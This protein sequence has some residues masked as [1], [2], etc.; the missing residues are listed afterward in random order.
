M[1]ITSKKI[2]VTSFILIC[3][4]SA[5]GYIISKNGEGNKLSGF[6][7]IT[8]P[9]NVIF[10]IGDGMGFNTKIAADYFQNGS[11]NSQQY[12]N[13]PVKYA[14]SSF[15]AK[16]GSYPDA[17]VWSTGY[18]PREM[19]NNFSY[20]L[21]DYTESAA[22]A[23]ALSTGVKTYNNSIGMDLNFQ[24]LVNLTQV[25][26]SL[27]KSAG[28]VT[29]V[30]FSHATPAGFVAHNVT[31]NNYSV[32]AF[33]MLLNSKVDVIMGAGNPDYDNDG[34]L[35]HNSYEFV[36][37]SLC[38]IGLQAGNSVFYVNGN[39]DTVEDC[40]NDGIRDPWTLIQDKIQ[41]QTLMNGNTPL[42]VLGVPKIFQT[43]QQSRSGDASA[44]PFVVPFNQTVPALSEMTKG[45]LN[46][47]DNNSNGFFLMVECGAIDWAA[48]G[49]QK[50][51]LIE[52]TI[53]LNNTVNAVI[54]WVNTH[55]NWN[56]TLVIIT[57][58]HETGMLWGPGSGRSAVFNPIV[59]N[60]INQ[61]PGMSFYS[62]GHTNSLVPFYAN[63]QGS[64]L[65]NIFADET[66]SVRGRF[67]QNSEIAQTI[68]CLWDAAYV[69]SGVNLTGT[70]TAK[71]F[72]LDQNYPNPFNPSTTISFNLKKKAS[73]SLKIFDITG[74]LVKNLINNELTE[75]G[76]KSIKYNASGL[77][78]GVY[79]YTLDADGKRIDAKKMV[80]IK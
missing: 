4:L 64:Q 12:D 33:E 25:A 8:P 58:D 28:V 74:R 66:D 36:G 42:R 35:S 78:S 77:S 15:P 16:T 1:K 14:V 20:A 54:E 46:V 5:A 55:S 60:G 71:E 17:L 31:R 45:A 56:E 49:N 47:L 26:K 65:F 62:T 38:W 7:T 67:I 37:D 9:K 43:L 50:G 10:I 6:R 76:I 57:A 80:F 63:G 52:E 73:V 2:S 32:I 30:E 53:E 68:K 70:E 40:N 75:A 48:H 21:S 22:S 23:T 41:F 3:I 39:P 11:I 72:T 61:V 79:F 34:L 44:D 29:S 19:W 27:N 24:P 59:N 13:F 18:N 69:I 51:R